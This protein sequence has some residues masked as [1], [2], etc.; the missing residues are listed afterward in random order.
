M[1]NYEICP[2][3]TLGLPGSAHAET[4][5]SFAVHCLVQPKENLA[6]GLPKLDVITGM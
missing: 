2:V 6:V 1:L 3:N 5:L 4:R